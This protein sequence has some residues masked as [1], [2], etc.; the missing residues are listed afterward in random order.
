MKTNRGIIRLMTLL[1]ILFLCLL[2]LFVLAEP[3]GWDDDVRLTNDPAESLE[4]EIASDSEGSVHII[5]KDTRQNGGIYYKKHDESGWDSDFLLNAGEDW[6]IHPNLAIDNQ[7]NIHV[8]WFSDGTGPFTYD[9]FYRKFEGSSWSAIEQITVVASYRNGAS[10]VYGPEIVIDSQNNIYVFWTADR[11]TVSDNRG[12]HYIVN[13]GGGWSDIF[14]IADSTDDH[15]ELNV[16]VDS[17]NNIHIVYETLISGQGAFVD[18][19]RFDGS[20]WSGEIRISDLNGVFPSITSDSNDNLHVLWTIPAFPAEIMYAKLDN[21]GIEIINDKRLSFNG[22]SSGHIDCESDIEDNIHLVWT[23]RDD[24][25][26]SNDAISYMKINN[27][28]DILINETFLSYTATV[29]TGNID[30]YPHL[31]ID[32]NQRIHIVFGD[33]RDGNPEIYY[34]STLYYDLSIFPSSIEFSNTLPE[35]NEL[36]FINATIINNGGYLTNA[37]IYFY[38]DNINPANIIDSIFVQIPVSGSELTSIQW[39]AITGTHTIWI[40]IEAENGIVESN[41]TNN[42]ASKTVTVNDPPTIAINSPPTGITT[43]DSTYSISWI[44]DDPDDEAN[45]E[46]YYDDDNKGY[47]GAIIVT[48]DQYPSGIDDNNGG[49]QS[50]NWDTTGLTDGSSYYIYAKIDDGLHDPIYAY[51]PGKI[52]IDHQNVAPSV[53]IDSPLDG[54]VSGIVTIHGT[55]SDDVTVSIVEIRIDNE[56]WDEA[57]GTSSWTYEWYTSSYTNG[58]HTITARAKDNSG[59]Y[60]LEDSKTVTVNNGSNLVPSV[61]INSHS[62]DSVVSGTVEI[63]GTSQDNDGNVELVEIKIDNGNWQTASGTLSWSYF[64]DTTSFS[65]GEHEIHV[66]AKDNSQE[67]SQI[68]SITLIV[69]NGGNI[70]PIA[71]IISPSGGTVSGSVTIRGSASDLDGDNTLSFVEIKI[72]DDWES[73]NGITEWSYDWDTTDLD[74]GTYTIFARAYDGIEY[75]LEK[76]VEVSVDNPH[77]PT[78][79]ITSEIP[80]ETTGILKLQ[81]TAS[82]VDGDIVKIEIQIDDGEWEEILGTM[83]WNYDLDTTELS[84][85]EHT[86]RI[87]ALDDEGEYYEESFTINVNNSSLAIWLILIVVIILILVF[88]AA[89]GLRRKKPQK[90]ATEPLVS[91]P[92]TQTST[93]SIKCPQCSNVFEVSDTIST[94]QCPYCGTRGSLN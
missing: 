9:I 70:P 74:D 72:E 51:S 89:V 50:Y 78:L 68:E 52:K 62:M 53:V 83:N 54:D 49:S 37:T 69:N 63:E 2:Q 27:I 42:I 26:H 23:N 41:L 21:I 39:S 24:D 46:L 92:A 45:I 14:E 29:I 8:M 1:S 64:W 82:D 91:Q 58:E 94:V 13:N 38:L 48:T 57:E 40:E 22:Y 59:L 60:S 71:T 56:P 25:D 65:N 28:G 67:Y 20:D 77:E 34:K 81:G 30:E 43:V 66:R 32:S 16:C 18:Y 19:K 87:R 7:D 44:A 10:S 17:N 84:D 31:D 3:I 35:N 88:I 15:L 36:I 55:A 90:V 33:D 85:G 86:I 61:E 11:S 79:T 4:P 76:S 6:G 73:V 93:Q 47:D 75:S 5:W 80:E 12:V